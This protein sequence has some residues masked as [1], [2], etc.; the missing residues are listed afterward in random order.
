V[1][2]I[3]VFKDVGVETSHWI[4]SKNSDISIEE[5]ITEEGNITK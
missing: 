3:A 5:A 1:I 4:I 2:E